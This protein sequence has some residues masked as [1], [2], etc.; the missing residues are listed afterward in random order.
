[1]KTFKSLMLMSLLLASGLSFADASSWGGTLYSKKEAIRL[2]CLSGSQEEC[3]E[4]AVETAYVSDSNISGQFRRIKVMQAPSTNMWA[5][6]GSRASHR[7]INR[8]YGALS[9]AGTFIGATSCLFAWYSCPYDIVAGMIFD[10]YKL[11]LVA[12]GFIAHHGMGPIRKAKM[13][14]NI[15]FLSNPKNSGAFK[16]TSKA[17]VKFILKGLEAF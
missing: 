6:E 10:A 9:V 4:Y 15:E 5:T 7:G 3:E 17:Q 12:A 8:G 14:K 16:K 1:M 11:P 13:A 2:V